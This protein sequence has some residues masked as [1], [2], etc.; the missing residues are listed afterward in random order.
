MGDIQ[1]ARFF[2][3]LG[4]VWNSRSSRP[5]HATCPLDRHLNYFS[6]LALLSL[7]TVTRSRDRTF[8]SSSFLILASH[9]HRHHHQAASSSSSPLS[10][11]LL[12]R[13]KFSRLAFFVFKV[14]ILSGRIVSRATDER[15]IKS[16]GPNGHE[17]VFLCCF[18]KRER[19][20]LLDA[21]VCVALGRP[22]FSLFSRPTDGR[23]RIIA[24]LGVL[25]SSRP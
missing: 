18:P 25:A 12:D 23:Q 21:G 4:S 15:V 20:D 3:R 16:S 17:G 2:R 22:S 6:W 1:K 13:G 24:H 19:D 14:E 8:S 10:T 11:L 7:S 9:H 5:G